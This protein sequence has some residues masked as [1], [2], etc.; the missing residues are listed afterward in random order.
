MAMLAVQPLQQL[1][2]GEGGGGR[3]ARQQSASS[4]CSAGSGGRRRRQESALSSAGSDHSGQSHRSAREDTVC[5]P[6]Y[7]HGVARGSVSLSRELRDFAGFMALTADERRMRDDLIAQ[8]TAVAQSLWP[9]SVVTVYGSYAQCTSSPTSAVDLTIEHVTDGG[10]AQEAFRSLGEV[11]SALLSPG[12]GEGFLQIAAPS[13]AVANV[14]L[15]PDRHGGALAA[16]NDTVRGWLAEFPAAAP[17]LAAV[18][19]VLS[20]ACGDCVDVGNGGLSPYTL[21]ALVIHVCRRSGPS[22]ECDTVLLNFMQYFGKDF[23]FATQ[24]VD[25]ND[26]APCAR[27]PAHAEEQVSVRDPHDPENN[28][29]AGCTRLRQIRAHLQSCLIA[30]RRWDT[31]PAA[32]ERSPLSMIVSHQP[33]WARGQQQLP[34]FLQQQQR[35]RQ[36]SSRQSSQADDSASQ[37]SQGSRGSAR[38]GPRRDRAHELLQAGQG[39][40]VPVLYVPLPGADGTPTRYAP[41]AVLPQ[42][43]QPVAAMPLRPGRTSPTSHS[44][45]SAP[46]PGAVQHGPV[47]SGGSSPLGAG[48]PQPGG[49]F[50]G[51]TQWALSGAACTGDG[52]SSSA[53]GRADGQSSHGS[54]EGHPSSRDSRGRRTSGRSSEPQEPMLTAVV[55]FRFG[56]TA[57]YGI[58]ESA[59]GGTHVVVTTG[60]GHHI[61]TVTAMRPPRT[62]ARLA[63]PATSEEIAEWARVAQE[64]AEALRYMRE[65]VAQHQVPI[66][67]HGAEYQFDRRK[68]TFHYSSPVPRPPFQSL[69]HDMYRRYRCRIWMN[70]CQPRAG[71]PGESVDL[72]QFL[73]L[74]A[75][76]LAAA[77]GCSVP[78]GE[79]VDPWGGPLPAEDGPPV[80]PEEPPP[81]LSPG[82][83]HAEGDLPVLGTPP[84][85]PPQPAA[86]A[87]HSLSPAAGE[88]P[89]ASL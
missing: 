59:P 69:L 88:Q 2:A 77:S 19:H 87:P 7:P 47:G 76:S 70:N 20:Q 74:N 56:R 66:T 58:A 8:C 79:H 67:V 4:Q 36:P 34:Q 55:A 17:V 61:G 53:A 33:L 89:E 64:E 75:P 57:E 10:L 73:V 43:G 63:R 38:A 81:P 16:A 71:E 35:R 42:Q 40:Y 29:A 21:L 54:S 52:A 48:A 45:Q 51:L 25:P 12:S 30:L 5:A 50:G 83:A 11:N 72:Q 9:G 37:H 31:E 3:R 49:A 60:R 68:L 24:C 78:A 26:G 82:S 62:H 18:R 1:A 39:G 80:A 15:H 22:A 46:S 65:Q 23:D 27:P 84:Q 14:S 86:E 85:T 41:V 6:W 44:Q 28:L 32:R 13:G